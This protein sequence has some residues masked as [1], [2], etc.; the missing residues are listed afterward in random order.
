MVMVKTKP[1][2]EEVL[3]AMDKAAEGAGEMLQA[4]AEAH[5]D[6]AKE[7]GDLFRTH[8]PTAGYSRL[9]KIIKSL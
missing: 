4:W 2:K 3:A 1:T 8:V 9:G 6:A 5:P 7:L